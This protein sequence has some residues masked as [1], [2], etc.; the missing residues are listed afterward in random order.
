[1]KSRRGKRRRRRGEEEGGEVREGKWEG[2]E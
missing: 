2:K 1:M